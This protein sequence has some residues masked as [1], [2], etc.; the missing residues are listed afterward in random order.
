MIRRLLFV[1][2]LVPAGCSSSDDT[3]P[4]PPAPDGL[5]C[6][7]T[8]GAGDTVSAEQS[9]LSATAG[10]CVVLTGTS[11]GELPGVKAGVIVTSAKGARATVKKAILEGGTLAH[12]DVVGADGN[13]V[14]SD[15]GAM[16]DVKV[17]RAKYAALA[18]AAGDLTLEDVHLEASSYG[19]VAS[20]AKVTAK[21]GRVGDNGGSGLTAGIGVVA[22]NGARLVFDGVVIEKNQGTGILI[23]GKSTVLDAK[24]MKVLDNTERGIW[25][26]GVE[27]TLD[28]PGMRLED[29]EVARNHIVGVGAFESHGIIVVGGRVAETAATPVVTNLATTEPVG[30]GI[31]VFDRAGDVKIDGTLVEQNARA[32]GI[33]DG[34]DRGIIVVGGKVS[35]SSS[36]LKFVVQNT[37]ASVEIGD[38]MKSVSDKP[39]GVAA[40]KVTVPSL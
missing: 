21:G 23:D 4:A 35:A 34:S 1:L 10:T 8:V 14:T 3:A 30:D 37:T 13:G 38:D 12:I 24:N 33:V 19:L 25:M 28:A 2:L 11:Y 17:S 40:S 16:I 32:A 22:T 18:A 36:G 39:L 9:I 26:Q 31:G 6:R 29:C 5:S 27:G 7:S 15:G 20:G